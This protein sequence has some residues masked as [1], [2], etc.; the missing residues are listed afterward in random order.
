M[1]PLKKLLDF[2]NGL[3]IHQAICAVV[4]LGVPDLLGRGP[5]SA[6]QLAAELNVNEDALYRTMRALAGQGVFEETRSREFANS[7]VSALLRHDVLGSIRPAFLYFGTDFYYQ[8]FG[9]LLHCIQSGER[10]AKLF[11]GN[12]WEYMQQRPELAM[13]FDDAMT[14]MSVMQAPAIA[15]AYDFGHWQTLMDVGG[16]NGILLS[17]ILRRH[18]SLRGVLADQH[19]VLERA[20]KRGFLAGDL[21]TR[22]AMQDCDFFREVPPGCRAYVMKN[23]IHDWNDSEALQILRNCRRVVP[24]DGVLLLVEWLLSEPNVPS[25]GKM[26]DLIMLVLTGGR[27]RTVEQYRDLLKEIGFCL[28]RVFPTQAE[29]GIFEALPT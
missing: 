19:H 8:P 2:R 5:C 20:R 28:N 13:I 22:A 4:K 7:E 11:R 17:H 26:S 9:E 16:G 14:N 24:N 23:V 25:T 3:I 6:A 15:D 29:L 12:D 27:E 1:E 18:V 21:A 10:A